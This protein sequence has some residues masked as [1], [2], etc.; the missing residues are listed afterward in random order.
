M[1]KSLHHVLLL[2]L[3]SA[4][5]CPRGMAQTTAVG[6]SLGH[7]G[8][9]SFKIHGL[10]SNFAQGF[11]LA[12]KVG[13]G[14]TSVDPGHAAD[15]RRIFINDATNGTPEQSGRVWDFRGDLLYKMKWFSPA[16][17]Y[18][19][20]GIRYA[21]FAGDFKFVGGNEDFEVTSDQ[22]GLGTGLEIH[23]P[24]NNRIDLVSTAGI[25]YYLNNELKGHDTVYSPDGENINPR[26]DY[27]FTNA[28]KA[29]NQPK[30]EFLLM[31]GLN[32]HLK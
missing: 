13:I 8:G 31:I 6:F 29:I 28:D 27:T 9:L 17:S 24:I 3:L 12:V 21:A 18:I 32:Y 23:F 2:L 16:H 11:P 19:Y 1:K 26:H 30:V 22:W 4:V 10:L 15:A 7:N 14:Y 5:L 25:D 20:A